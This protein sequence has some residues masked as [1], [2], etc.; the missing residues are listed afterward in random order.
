MK[1]MKISLGD[2]APVERAAALIAPHALRTPV[3]TNEALDRVF[4]CRLFFKCEN[5]QKAGAF[6]F[7]GACH[8][9]LTL[10]DEEKARGVITVSSG[11]HGAA[12]S[13]AG[14]A[15]G[16]SVWVVTPD[17]ASPVK[18][19]NMESNGAVLHFC[20]PGMENRERMLE[21]KRAESGRHVIHPFNDPRIIAGQG[22][23]GLELLEEVG[24]LDAVFTPIGGGGLMSGTIVTFRGKSPQTKI[25][26][27]EPAG[28]DDAYRSFH[29]GRIEP[30]IDPK[31][32]CDGLLTSLGSVTF[33]IIREGID[34][35]IL[36]EDDEIIQAMRWVWE[37]VHII[38][39]PSSAVALAAAYKKR[40]A[41]AGGRVGIIF[42]GGNVN[43]DALPWA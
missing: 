29:S 43:L 9:L 35:I 27:G 23:A 14:K 7:R 36:V 4:G 17:N 32:I 6:K 11:N 2:A 34:D 24:K 15:L 41:L 21:E 20:K 18:L 40:E 16:I 39:E 10:T 30:S 38:I 19:K 13:M 42:S 33:P 5:L 3:L 8:T 22:T 31:T 28:A 1:D 37:K 26:G 12:L 25:Y